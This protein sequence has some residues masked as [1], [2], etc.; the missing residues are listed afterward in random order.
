MSTKMELKDAIEL[1]EKLKFG[2]LIRITWCDKGITGYFDKIT[3][4]YSRGKPKSASI[5]IIAKIPAYQTI[6]K[7]FKKEKATRWTYDFNEQL[8][9]VELLNR[10]LSDDYFNWEEVDCIN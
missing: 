10:I 7:E 2:D 4:Y 6:S 9:N 3:I 8:I 1:E 5:V